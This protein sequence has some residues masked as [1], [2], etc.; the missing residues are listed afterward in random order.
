[1]IARRLTLAAVGTLCA[2]A[3]GLVLASAPA[4]AAEAPEAPAPVVVE[5]VKA[6]SAT[7]H[8]DLNPGKE[9]AEGTYELGT[10]EFLYK[11]SPTECQGGASAPAPPG[12]S[13][14]GGMEA[15]PSQEVGGLES[16]TEYT[17]C[18]LARNGTKGEATVGPAVTFTTATAP[19][20]PENE[21]ATAVT[22]TTA[23][24][25]GTLNPKKAGEAGTYEFVYEKSATECLGPAG[26]SG[27]L[28]YK[29]SP[30]PAGAS[31]GSTPEPVH[32]EVTGLLSGAQYTFCLMAHNT[33]G[34]KALSAPVTFTTPAVPPTIESEFSS[35]VAATSATLGAQIDPGGAETTYHFEYGTSETYEHSTSESPSIGADDSGHAASAH[36]QGLAPSTIYHYRVVVT[37]SQSLAGMAGPDRTFTT[38]SLG[39]EMALPDARAWELVSPAHKEGSEAITYNPQAAA[40]GGAIAYYA[41]VSTEA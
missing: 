14:G 34:E 10:Y 25:K 35:D 41:T 40:D 27:E 7:F 18:L 20:A 36:I 23:T 9:G 3:G 5:S 24:L 4:L 13:L 2:L 32:T 22:G 31:A 16:H 17:V 26:A 29:V 6:T 38:P 11:Q 33:A 21:E 28:P 8:G 39:A 15:L 12:I 1:M 37:S 19:E 30:E